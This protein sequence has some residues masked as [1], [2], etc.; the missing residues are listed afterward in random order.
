MHLMFN[1]DDVAPQV[2]HVDI[3][4]RFS[5]SSTSEASTKAQDVLP[6]ISIPLQLYMATATQQ[7][8]VTAPTASTM[9]ELVAS[10]AEMR[11][12]CLRPITL[13]SFLIAESVAGGSEVSEILCGESVG[14]LGIGGK[15]WDSTFVLIRYLY[16]NR[17]ELVSGKRILELGAGTGITSLALSRLQP[18]M[19]VCTD[20]E[21]V[22]PLI[23]VN[24]ELNAAWSP[25]LRSVLRNDYFVQPLSWG[26]ELLPP[27]VG[28][29]DVRSCEVIIASD[30][31]YY[32]EGY[33]P[34]LTT[35]ESLLCLPSDAGLSKCCILA[36]RH[37]HPED[38]RFF[39]MLFASL[40][41]QVDE[42]MWRETL[43]NAAVSTS[44]AL[45]DVRLFR[46]SAK[47]PL[48]ER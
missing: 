32:P 5:I 1:G 44:Q 2:D 35:L 29:A 11:V 4:L 38:H 16:Q 18:A 48:P 6:V 21:E 3:L 33:E 42:L 24:V 34:L 22:V 20:L 41:L 47:A 39:S 15:I 10:I 45:Q 14:L 26:G 12:N 25:S 9:I 23:K 36:H 17:V 30:V 7:S 19:V 46:I 8:I 37:R 43:F 31:V 27:A 13:P 28:G 40:V